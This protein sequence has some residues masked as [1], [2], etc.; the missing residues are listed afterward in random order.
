MMMP[1]PFNQQSKVYLYFCAFEAREGIISVIVRSQMLKITWCII[2]LL[3]P[4]YGMNPDI[5]AQIFLPYK[6]TRSWQV[7]V[8]SY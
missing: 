1:K 6:M 3:K 2:Q 4:N 8:F 7:S 5:T